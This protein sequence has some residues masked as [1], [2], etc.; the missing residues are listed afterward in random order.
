[1]TVS[2]GFLVVPW[3]MIGELYPQ[4]VRGVIG[5]LTTCCAHTFVFI[6]VKTYPFLAHALYQHGAFMLYGCISIVGSIFFYLCLP[7]TKG[8][9]LQEIEDYFSGRTKTLDTKKI[10]STT[11]L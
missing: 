3:V 7:E 4:K 2:L 10:K 11:K 1:M 9:S 8:K 6:V 5:G